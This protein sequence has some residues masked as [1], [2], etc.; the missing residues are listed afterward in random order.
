MVIRYNKIAILQY[1]LLYLCMLNTASKAASMFGSGFIIFTFAISIL[2]FLFRVVKLHR[3][4]FYAIFC[5]IGLIVLIHTIVLGDISINSAMNLLSKFLISYVA[6]MIDLNNFVK[7][8]IK[9]VIFMAAVSLV[10][11]TLTLTNADTFVK[12]LLITNNAPC[13]TGNISYGR[14]FYHYMPGYERNV[15]IYNE[16]GVFQIYLN[17]ALLLVLFK[18]DE[19]QIKG[20]SNIWYSIILIITIFTTMSTAGYVEMFVIIVLYVLTLRNTYSSCRIAIILSILV[21]AMIFVRTDLF[22][23]IVVDK[24]AWSDQGRFESGTGN[25]R[26]ASV[27]LDLNYITNNPLGYG[28]SGI[29]ENTSTFASSETGSS[30]GLTSMIYVYGIPIAT[31]IYLLYFYSL[32]HI[33]NNLL[34]KI[35]LISS[36]LFAFSSQPWI[37]TPAYLTLMIY[38]LSS[39][40]D[41]SDLNQQLLYSD[42]IE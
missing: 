9:L 42:D 16:P 1:F 7:R 39:T 28:Y 40:M 35:A 29:W 13:W 41:Y 2:L 10:F 4:H 26:I 24:L 20:K 6:V 18:K 32:Y 36:F 5:V 15:G 21:F 8:F 34:E 33:G 23:N 12:A 11:F 22:Q 19:I 27:L 38:G 3:R 25:A 37:L 17:L 30:V 31:I 14:F